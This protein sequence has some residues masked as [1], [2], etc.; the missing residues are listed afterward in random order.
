M[1]VKGG[2]GLRSTKF[3]FESGFLEEDSSGK[4]MGLDELDRHEMS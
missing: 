4:A 3:R 1:C 2:G